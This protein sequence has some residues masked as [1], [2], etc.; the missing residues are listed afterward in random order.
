M[1]HLTAQMV[2]NAING[3]PSPLFDSHDAEKAVLRLHVVETAR[4]ILHQPDSSDAL[5][6]FS[7]AFARYVDQA[8][9][10]AA[11]QIRAISTVESENLGGEVRTNPLWKKLVATVVPPPS[12]NGAVGEAGEESYEDDRRQRAIR[13]IGLR[14]AAG[15]ANEDL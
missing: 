5:G 4:E 12:S 10:G 8:F 2:A 6:S 1:R 14:N 11:A 7:A 3:A 13:A 9:A 15:R